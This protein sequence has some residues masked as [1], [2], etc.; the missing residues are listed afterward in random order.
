MLSNFWHWYVIIITLVTIF[1]C[2]WLL[3]WTKGVSNR[4]E[5][6]TSSTGHVWDGD[7]Q[8]L[9][10]PLPR[11]W[12][13][14]FYLTIVFALGYLI[15]FPGFGN[16]PGLLGWSQESQYAEEMQAARKTQ[17]AIFSKYMQLDDE[18]LIADPEANATGRRLFANHCA[19]CHGS[20]ARGARGFPNLTDND[21]LY[22]NS[23]ATVMQTIENG[24][25][26]AMPAIGAGFKQNEVAEL[27][28]YVQSLSGQQAD[29][30][31]AASGKAR[32][33]L[34]CAA[35]HGP[36]GS[37]NQAL[38]AP[39]L[40]DSV[41]LYGGDP[42]TIAETIRGGRNGHMPAHKDLLSPHQRRLIAAFVLSLGGANNA[43]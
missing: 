2:W 39:R 12:L 7:L 43:P 20:D 14:L 8:E 33:T 1:A 16:F 25:S 34:F 30:D 31:M 18:A 15:I 22:G 10:N 21:W 3:K 41:W 17:E 38:G 26:G 27:V 6:E 19:M 36:D 23:F 35:C 42:E 9:N 37:G 13:Q 5:G 32:F 24:R 29:T 11:W 40:N 28:V 4:K